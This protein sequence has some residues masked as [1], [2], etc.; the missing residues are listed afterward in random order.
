M[1]T[2][3]RSRA[4]EDKDRSD[5]VIILTII[6]SLVIIPLLISVVISLFS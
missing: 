4:T 2:E 3:I 5:D 1:K 6:A